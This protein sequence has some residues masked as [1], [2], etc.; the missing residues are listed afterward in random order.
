MRKLP[1]SLESLYVG[2]I[3]EVDGYKYQLVTKCQRRPNTFDLVGLNG[4]VEGR[5]YKG[6]QFL[7]WMFAKYAGSIRLWATEPALSLEEML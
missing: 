3:Y 7:E 1:L 4:R 2:V 6:F 5:T